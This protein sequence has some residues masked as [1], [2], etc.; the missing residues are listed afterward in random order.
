[1]KVVAIPISGHSPPTS[2]LHDEKWFQMLLPEMN[3]FGNGTLKQRVPSR[4]KDQQ[5]LRN[6]EGVS[7]GA[8]FQPSGH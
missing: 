5:R 1:M 7:W 4:E 3:L 2:S 6:K 8:T